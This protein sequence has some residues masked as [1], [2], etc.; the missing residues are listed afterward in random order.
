MSLLF[1][2]RLVGIAH[3]PLGLT[4]NGGIG[5]WGDTSH[6]PPTHAELTA[7]IVA[8]PIE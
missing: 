7:A 5:G 1:G 3:Q 8:I 2:L 4:Q 6:C